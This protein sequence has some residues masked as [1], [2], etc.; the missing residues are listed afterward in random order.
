MT[1]SKIPVLKDTKCRCNQGLNPEI[2]AFQRGPSFRSRRD[3]F[4][5]PA[6]AE[7]NRSGRG[8]E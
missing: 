2:T 7:R 1:V 8:L 6:A 5:L 4:A 3:G